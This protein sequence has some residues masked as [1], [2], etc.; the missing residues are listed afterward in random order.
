MK[1]LLGKKIGMTQIYSKTGKAIPVT[2]IEVTPNVVTQVKTLENDGYVA[3]QLSFGDIRENLLTKSQKTHFAKA[4]T[5]AKK[6]TREIRDMNGYNLGDN[7]TASI[8]Q[9]GEMVD[10]ASVSKGHGFSGPIKRH[11]QST[12]PMGHGSGYHRGVGSMGSI[13]NNRIFKG[14]NM[15]GQ[16]GHDNTTVQNLQI[17][18]FSEENNF[19]LVSGAI[20][21]PKNSLVVIYESIKHPGVVKP[22]ELVNYNTKKESE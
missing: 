9:K 6:Y 19:V 1:G 17:V 8:F 12:G 22:I 4:N 15:P 11:N 20:P 18:D 7:V 5:T 3:T 21:G 13:T 10:V 14:K 16:Y 2:V